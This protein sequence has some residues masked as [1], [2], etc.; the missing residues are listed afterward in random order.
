MDAWGRV[1][2]CPVSS[3]LF[4]CF[5]LPS[6]PGEPVDITV[7]YS[8]IIYV[9]DPK[10]PGFPDIDGCTL[11]L[12]LIP[13]AMAVDANRD[14]TIAFSGD[15]RDTTSQAAT[16]RFWCNDDNDGLPNSEGDV[17]NPSIPRLRRWRHS[18]G[19]RFGGLCQASLVLRRIPEGVDRWRVQ[20]RSKV[21]KRRRHSFHNKGIQ[22][23]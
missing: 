21:Q 23:D 4:M 22:I 15:T 6:R 18:D 14:G 9:D 19:A 8:N 7:D 1:S 10:S 20:D 16:F 11:F 2:I 5:Q 13:A 12:Y 3:T 17:I